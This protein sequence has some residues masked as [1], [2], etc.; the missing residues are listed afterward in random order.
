MG[1]KGLSNGALL[2]RAADQGFDAIVTTD[3]SVADQQNVAALP[4]SLVIL[5]APS[6]NMADLEPLV[7]ALLR[8]LNH[9]APKSVVH[10][11]P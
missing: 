5:H 4:V 1:W 8:E 3:L 2:A 10:V 6:N 11:Y 9:L 7:L